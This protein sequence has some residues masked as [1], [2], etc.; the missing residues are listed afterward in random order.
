MNAATYIVDDP[1]FGWLSFGGNLRESGGRVVVT[2]LDAM[3]RRVYIAPFGLWLTL[4][5]GTFTSIEI[6]KKARIVRVALSPATAN[7]AIGRLRIEQPAKVNGV[8]IFQPHTDLKSERG[9]YVIPLGNRASQID[10]I[11]K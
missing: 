6:D 4:D 11:A 1:E 3:R 9:A 8:G 10:L 5:A 7:V 2:P